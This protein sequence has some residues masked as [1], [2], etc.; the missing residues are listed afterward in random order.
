MNN[1]EKDITKAIF[2]SILLALTMLAGA[3]SLVFLGKDPIKKAIPA[4][5][6]FVLNLIILIY[7][8]IV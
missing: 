1:L 3:G 7:L 8:L 4:I 2:A 5:V 6:L